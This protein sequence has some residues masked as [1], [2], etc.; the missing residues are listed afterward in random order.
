VAVDAAAS[1]TVRIALSAWFWVCGIVTASFLGRLIAAA[2]R[3]VPH[4]LP[5]EYIYP[6]LARSFAEH[7]RRVTLRFNVPGGGAWSLHFSS[8]KQGYIADRAVSV[9]SPVVSFR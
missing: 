6:S 9:L 3:P 5:D 1:R 7:G 2:G 8:R 4:Y